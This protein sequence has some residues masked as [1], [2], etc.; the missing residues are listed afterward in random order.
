MELW[1]VIA[2]ES[3][4]DTVTRYNSNGDSARFARVIELFTADAV[5]DVLGQTYTGHDEIMTIFTGVVT[6]NAS[7]TSPGHVRHMTATHQIDF[8]DESHAT[9]RLYF[10]VLTKVGL[11]HWG[12]YIDQYRQV[13]GAWKFARRKVIVDGRSPDSTFPLA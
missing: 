3:I 8:V 6:R 5:M 1:E 4:R 13:D 12:R 10:Q 2:R 9:G 11:D 7:G